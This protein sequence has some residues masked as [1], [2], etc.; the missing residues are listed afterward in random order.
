MSRAEMQR[1]IDESQ[2][3]ASSLTRKLFSAQPWTAE[4]VET[5]INDTGSMTIATTNADTTPHAALVVAGSQDGVIYFSASPGSALL[6][7]LR[8]RPAVAFTVGG[9]VSGRGDA[10]LAGQPGDLP[11]LEPQ[12]SKQLRELQ[13]TNWNG[14]IYE[15]RLKR[16][17]AN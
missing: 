14:Y 7:N 8:R 17:F 3:T 16:L 13:A 2:L 4:K 5:F 11:A 10:V 12:V 1:I 6:G 15:L 9:S